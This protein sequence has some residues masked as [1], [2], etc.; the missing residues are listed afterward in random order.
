MTDNSIPRLADIVPAF[1]RQPEDTGIWS[2]TDSGLFHQSMPNT[3]T[4]HYNDHLD[5]LCMEEVTVDLSGRTEACH[6]TAVGLAY[7]IFDR[8]HYP[9]CAR[10]RAGHG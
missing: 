7:D 6:Q 5:G 4:Q 8:Q 1:P 3:W 2:Q 10:H 9:V